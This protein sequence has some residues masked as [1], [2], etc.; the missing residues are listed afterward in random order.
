MLNSPAFPYTMSDFPRFA[1]LFVCYRLQSAHF[2]LLISKDAFAIIAPQILLAH[3]AGPI[4]TLFFAPK[5]REFFVILSTDHRHYSSV[6]QRKASEQYL[7]H[8]YFLCFLLSI[9]PTSHL[10]YI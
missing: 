5:R 7:G 1:A 8:E 6:L 10:S 2:H 9:C 4:V 3:P